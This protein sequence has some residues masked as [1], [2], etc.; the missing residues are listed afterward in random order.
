MHKVRT[1]RGEMVDFD[2]LRVKQSLAATP[3][4]IQV[5]AREEFV[6]QRLKRRSKRKA[7]ILA[8]NLHDELSDPV[9]ETQT[10]E[11][12]SVDVAELDQVE[13]EDAQPTR[14]TIKRKQQRQS[15]E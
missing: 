14:T 8:Q 7:A 9:I 4:N 15:E 12:Q 5:K 6:D 1:A 11:Q 2:E 3:A 13:I 10:D